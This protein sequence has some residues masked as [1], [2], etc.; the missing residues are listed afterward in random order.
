MRT[1][2]HENIFSGQYANI[3]V[4]RRLNMNERKKS[5]L[6]PSEL[7]SL[8]NSVEEPNGNLLI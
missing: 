7:Y 1:H 2:I 8:V 6:Y 3:L 4:D 5:E